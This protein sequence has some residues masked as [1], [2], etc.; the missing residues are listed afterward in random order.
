VR[1]GF[2]EQKQFESIYQILEDPYNDML[3][4]SYFTGWRKGEIVNLKWENID[5][6][7]NLIR[8]YPDETKNGRVIVKCGVWEHD[9]AALL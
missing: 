5:K 8:L 4:L 7:D 6:E 1:K 3:E 9:Q 2:F